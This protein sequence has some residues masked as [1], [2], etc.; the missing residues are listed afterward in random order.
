QLAQDPGY[1][2]FCDVSESVSCTQVYESRFGSVGGVPVALFGA[3]WF[4]LVGLLTMTAG[5]GDAG[6][7]E[8]IGAYLLVLSTVGL[9]AVLFLGYE[10][11]VVLGTFCMLCAVVYVAVIGIFVSASAVSTA[12]LLS[13]PRRLGS[14]IGRLVKTPLAVGVAGG[15]L[16]LTVG[17]GLA[18]TGHPTDIAPASSA[19]TRSVSD[20]S[21]FERFWNAQPRVELPVRSDGARVLVL[22]FNDYQCPSCAQSYFLYEPIFARYESSHPGAVRQLSLDYPLDPECNDQTPRGGHMGACA[23]AVAVR[24]A[25]REGRDAAMARWLYDNQ[26]TMS[27]ETVRQGLADVAGMTDFDQQYETVLEEVKADIALGALIDIDATP[28]FVI[29]GVVIKGGLQPQLFDS[30]IALEL[31]ADDGTAT[32]E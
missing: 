17:V 18:F 11:F 10:S 14:D 1:T 13:M 28:T 32:L 12:P 15:Y 9:A 16:A 3:F 30:A 7:D 22:K 20:D 26:P 4:G 25:R 6:F 31:A 21:E 24:L 27:R 8:S 19:A 5:R 23:A 2:S 29:N